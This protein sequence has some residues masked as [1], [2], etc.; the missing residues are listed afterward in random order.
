MICFREDKTHIKS[1]ILL[2][3]EACIYVIVCYWFS[4][5]R[6]ENHLPVDNQIFGGSN[7]GTVAIIPASEDVPLSNFS[8][9]LSLALHAIGKEQHR[10]IIRETNRLWSFIKGPLRLALHYFC[11]IVKIVGLCHLRS[12][13]K[14]PLTKDLIQLGLANHLVLIFTPRS[15]SSINKCSGP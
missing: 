11:L 9:E 15:H 13:H 1:P 4:F 7:L 8:F 2:N 3:F 10:I 12:S 5:S 14:I 6:L